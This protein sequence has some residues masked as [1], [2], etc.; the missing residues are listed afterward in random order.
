VA[1]GAL[2][3]LL[4]GGALGMTLACGLVRLLESVIFGVSPYDL[5]TFA[6]VPAV[7]LAVVLTA[8]YLPA[9]RATKADPVIALRYE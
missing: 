4:I 8:S 6:T 2:R 3:L 5:F 7:L 9:R 1:G